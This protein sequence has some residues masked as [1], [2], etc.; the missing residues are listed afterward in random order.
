MQGLAFWHLSFNY[1]KMVWEVFYPGGSPTERLTL[2]WAADY[3]YRDKTTR[4]SDFHSLED[5][6]MHSYRAQIIA[7]LKPWIQEQEPTLKLFDPEVLGSWIENLSSTCWSKALDWL[8]HRMRSK[9]H[10]GNLLNDHW[11]NHL[12]FCRMMEP[13]MTLCYAIKHGNIGLLRHALREVCLILQ[14]PSA[15]KSK[16][17]R[18]MLRRLHIFDTCAADP[19]LQEAYL[20]NSLVN[21]RGLASTFYEMDLLLEHQNGK[22]KRFR[23]DRGSSL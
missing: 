5:L 4:L 16:Y 14:A 7:M 1:L 19:V 15:N 20:A 9:K 10:E 17:A 8:E 12:R 13:Y 21:P 18:E 23:A 3:W 2:Q 6:T 22:I 11:N